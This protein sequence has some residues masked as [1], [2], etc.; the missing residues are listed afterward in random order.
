MKRGDASPC[1]VPPEADHV[2]DGGH[3]ACGELLIELKMTLD[4]LAEGRVLK[5]VSQDPGARV[6]L[7]VWCQMTRHTL[8]WSDND[9]YYIRRRRS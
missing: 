5:L 2:L 3:R 6:D 1:S 7:P 8:L 9:T 4:A